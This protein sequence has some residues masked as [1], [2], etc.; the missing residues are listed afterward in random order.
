MNNN[1]LYYV[2]VCPEIEFYGQRILKLFLIQDNI[3]HSICTIPCS[4]GDN[5]L[6]TIEDYFK[7]HNI[8]IQFSELIPL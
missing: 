6:L 4:T 2:E 5:L 3:P 1:I 8:D 7:T